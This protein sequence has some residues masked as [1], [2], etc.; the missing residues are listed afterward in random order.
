MKPPNTVIER[1]LGGPVCGECYSLLPVTGELNHVCLRCH[2]HLEYAGLLDE[3]ELKALKVAM[4]SKEMS[5]KAVIRHF[6]RMGQTMDHFLTKGSTIGYL[7]DQGDFHDPF[8]SGPKMAPMPDCGG[9][10]C[11]VLAPGTTYHDESCPKRTTSC[12][13]CGVEQPDPDE[14][15]NPDP[16]DI[17]HGL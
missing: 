11:K 15:I 3:R 5:A 14:R 2:P 7:G 8:D 4:D 6:F 17:R 12:W 9:T 13:E 16:G 10:R 1:G